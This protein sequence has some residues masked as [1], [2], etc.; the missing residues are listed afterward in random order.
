MI[1]KEC[2]I[3]IAAG[4]ISRDGKLEPAERNAEQ[5]MDLKLKIALIGA[6]SPLFA[7]DL[8]NSLLT[9]KEIY[10]SEIYLMDIDRERRDFIYLYARKLMDENGRPFEVYAAADLDEALMDADYVVVTIAIGGLSMR[11]HDIEIPLKYGIVHVK[12]DTTGPAGIFRALRSVPV[13]VDLV[14]RMEKLC[15]KALLINLSNPLTVITRAVTK[16]SRVKTAG[17]CTTIDG[18]RHQ[19]AGHLKVN[20]N[21]LELYSTGVN[22][23][24]WLQDIFLDG[25][26]CMKDFIEIVLPNYIKDLP[27]TGDLY[28]TYGCFPI[29]GYKYG[30][31]FFSWYLGPESDMGRDY[32]FEPD[33]PESRSK[34]GEDIYKQLRERMDNNMK[35]AIK[36]E[37]LD[38]KA[39]MDLIESTALSKP[40]VLNLNMPNY[41][42][43]HDLTYGSI[44]EGPVFVNGDRMQPLC[45]KRLPERIIKLLERV[46]YEQELVVE[47]ALNGDR[48]L[49]FEAFLMDPLVNSPW[50]ARKII[51]ELLELEKDYLPQ[52]FK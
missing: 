40:R 46:V 8:L 9:V 22:H 43:I 24:T 11:K 34:T 20:E 5:F 33:S 16:I 38:T 29:P 10:G 44:I 15:P 6:G 13:F 37:N 45:C 49:V 35:L 51:D 21:R 42:Q 41:G 50:N 18:M 25:R 14:K 19:I 1:C 4:C 52:F 17:I 39:I 26:D 28:K 27:V 7:S 3:I 30:S 47:A 23:F 12:S 36:S 2:I 48:E 31:E 32:G